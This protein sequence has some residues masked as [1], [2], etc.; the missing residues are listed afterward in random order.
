MMCFLF[1]QQQLGIQNGTIRATVLIETIAA[2]FEMDEILYELR[3]HSAGL[4]VDV[5]IIFLVILNG[6]AINQMYFTRSWA[7][8]DDVAIHEGLYIAL[9]SNLSSAECIRQ[10]VGWPHKFRLKMTEA[11]N[12]AAFGK[13]SEDKRREATDG[14]DGTWVAHP[15]LVAVAM[16]QFNEH[17]PT[18]NQIDRK[19]EDV[20]S[21]S[22]R[23]TGSTQREQLQNIGLANELQ[24]RRSIY[25][26]L[27]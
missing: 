12:A 22:R 18:P 24:C 25:R 15:G 20:Q 19:R 27:A 13:V 2:A 6:F 7:S 9:Y 23:F 10:S 3:D 14:H 21:Y 17:M 11:A 1:A 8:N 26:F 5:G 4:I 16:E